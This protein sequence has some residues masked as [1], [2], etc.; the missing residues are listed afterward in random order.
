MEG[1]RT[2]RQKAVPTPGPNIIFRRGAAPRPTPQQ[3]AQDLLEQLAQSLPGLKA[4]PVE[5]VRFADG[6]DGVTVQLSFDAAHL[7]VHQKHVFRVDGGSLTHGCASA[8]DPRA[9]ANVVGI[10]LSFRPS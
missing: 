3:C 1:P 7:T 8:P 5:T 4:Q 6:T 9:L 2:A 10:L